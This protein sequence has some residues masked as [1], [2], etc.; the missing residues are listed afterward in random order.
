MTVFAHQTGFQGKS[1]TRRGACGHRHAQQRRYAV[2]V[3]WG[4]TVVAAI[5]AA[6]FFAHVNYLVPSLL[7]PVGCSFSVNR[8]H[9]GALPTATVS[10]IAAV[11]LDYFFIPP[12]LEWDIN[13][14]EDALALFTYLVTSLGY[15]SS[16]NFYSGP[17]AISETKR[18]EVALLYETASRL[19]LLEPA[20]AAGRA[21]GIFRERFGLNAACLFDAIRHRWK[22]W[23][24]QT[25]TGGR[26]A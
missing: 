25:R 1:R 6:C 14:P 18:K 20:S 10:V 12:I 17:N 8:C 5:T 21:L 13:D 3:S 15:H 26:N 9:P 19:L 2:E 4:C 23:N 22:G 7:L 11:C 24:V 16:C